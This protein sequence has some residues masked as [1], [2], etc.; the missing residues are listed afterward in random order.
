M[1]D[2]LMPRRKLDSYLAIRDDV[3]RLFQSAML[4]LSK[5]EALLQQ[6]GFAQH[7]VATQFNGRGL[8]RLSQPDTYVSDFR[9]T[10]D[11]E[12]WAHLGKVS[13]LHQLMDVTA[14]EEW[15]KNLDKNAPECTRENIE[16]TFARQ[17]SLIF[18][19]GL[20]RAFQR[21]HKA[22]RSND[23]FKIGERLKI[24]SYNSGTVA[25][26]ERCL[27]LLDNRSVLKYDESISALINKQDYRNDGYQRVEGETP[28]FHF[29]Q[30]KNGNVHLRFARPDLIERCNQ[31]VAAFYGDSALP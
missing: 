22:F 26:I 9:T 23:A 20:V 14:R 27:C 15:E 30:Y 2:E 21:S 8:Y 10:I 28:Y 13:G 16:A 6:G 18:N 17:Q 31:I 1:C 4:D 3:I 24:D 19:R 11:R 5:A 12:L 29:K 7:K 25:D